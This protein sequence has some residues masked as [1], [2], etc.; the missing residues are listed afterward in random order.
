MGHVAPGQGKDLAVR[1]GRGTMEEPP[2]MKK[3]LSVSSYLID[4]LYAHGVRH[5][6][7][8]P[9]DYVLGFYRELDRSDLMIINTSDE[10]GAG[11]AADAYARV[12]GLGAVCITYSVGGLK[13]VNST[14]QAYAEKSPVVVISGAPG[15]D[16]RVGKVLLHH[17]VRDFDTQLKIFE[18]ITVASTVIDDPETACR[19]IDR[20]LDAALRHKRPVYIELPRDMIQT[21][22][23]LRRSACVEPA[24]SSPAEL[25]EALNEAVHIINRAKK[26]VIIAGVELHRFGLQDGLMRLL[27]NT[28]IPVAA[29]LLSKSV[30]R[31]NHPLYLG[32]Y[33]GAM[34]REEVRRYVESCDCLILLG[35]L[36]TDIDLGIFTAR[37]EQGRS[38]AATSEKLLIH[39]HAYEGV[40]V[41]D[42]L[43][44]L[45]KADIRRRE[46]SDMPHPLPPERPSPV[47]GKP[48]TVK[49]LF[50]CLNAFLDET[51]VVVADTGD[52]LFAAA[53]MTILS[54]TEFLSPAY[55]TSLG[56]A[57]PASLGVQ[58][59]KPHLRPLVLVGDG[60]FQMTGMELGVIARFNLNP[61]VIV[62]DNRG[63]GTE[64]PMLDG[65]FND[66]PFWDYSRIPEVL[67]AG[68]GFDVTTEDRLEEALREAK[69][70]TSG[71]S[72]LD[73]HLDPEDRS[74]ALERLSYALG[75]R[76][77]PKFPL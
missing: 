37:L 25:K 34:G 69:A 29:T 63:Y 68:R 49:Y 24:A 21:P 60:A 52:A 51:T 46:V 56:F 77:K 47:K 54:E 76:V 23:T 20:V 50:Q 3:P 26:P 9:G 17:R 73:V 13:V 44:G 31:E 16:E 55:Y 1:G 19:E 28:G 36:M 6:F 45:L 58:M 18:Q 75:A 64:R 41:E 11:F 40:G 15:R 22:V 27:E 14:A 39:Y 12:N 59:A 38:I 66:I 61:I 65:S 10:Q 33:E 43:L 70:Y 42:F 71:F 4:R 35:A 7:G 30:I 48:V 72:I 62:L 5:I 57:I 2:F 53:D 32:V 74:L 67:N 8:V